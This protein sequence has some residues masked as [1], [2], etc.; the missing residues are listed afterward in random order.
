MLTLNWSYS[1]NVE[2]TFQKETLLPCASSPLPTQWSHYWSTSHYIST[3]FLEWGSHTVMCL[4]GLLCWKKT[5]SKANISHKGEFSTPL[6]RW[7]KSKEQ[8]N[9][10]R[11]SENSWQLSQPW[12]QSRW[13][14]C[15]PWKG[16]FLEEVCLTSHSLRATAPEPKPKVLSSVV[17]VQ[18][19][20]H[21]RKSQFSEVWM[22]SLIGILLHT[23]TAGLCSLA[24][25][26]EFLS[27]KGK[28]V[29]KPVQRN[30]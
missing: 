9:Q 5:Y 6:W 8:L 27:L 30:C 28:G 29:G 15:I 14:S 7:W 26:E 19:T 4:H 2:L 13:V 24:K 12:V 18:H 11:H 16:K 25:A 23:G 20:F 22:Y 17:L 3:H 1:N 21:R 10:N